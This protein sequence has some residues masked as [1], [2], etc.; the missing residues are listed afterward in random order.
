MYFSFR[1]LLNPPIG[2]HEYIWMDV[3]LIKDTKKAILVM[4]DNRREWLPKAWIWGV[5]QNKNK[6]I[7][8][9][10]ISRYHWAKKFE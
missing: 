4:F 1:Y 3:T 5:K 2:L 6:N 10:K 9:I 7:V 8:K